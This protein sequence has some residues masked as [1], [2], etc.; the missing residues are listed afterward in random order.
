[1]TDQIQKIQLHLLPGIAEIR[2][3]KAIVRFML[4]GGKME[5]EEALQL[6]G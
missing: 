3:I 5:W 2:E 1:M 6:T 4:R